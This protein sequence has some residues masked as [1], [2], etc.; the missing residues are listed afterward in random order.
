L[1]LGAISISIFY[2]AWCLTVAYFS[3]FIFGLD[4]ND[5]PHYLKRNKNPALRLRLDHWVKFM[6]SLNGNSAYRRFGEE[7]HEIESP[8]WSGKTADGLAS[9]LNCHKA[10]KMMSYEGASYTAYHSISM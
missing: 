7:Q 3:L 2:L 9:P 8:A 6:Y 4:L 5:A 1:L 10:A